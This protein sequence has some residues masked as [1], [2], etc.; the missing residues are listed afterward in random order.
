MNKPASVAADWEPYWRG[1]ADFAALQ[2]D[3]PLTQHWQRMFDQQLQGRAPRSLLDVASGNGA[4]SAVA[5]QVLPAL[6]CCGLDLSPAALQDYRQ[7]CSGAVGVL[8]DSLQ[9]PFADA[10]FDLV[11]SQFGF[12][13]A[14]VGA[15]HEMLRMVAPGGSLLAVMHLRD[16]AI[17][18]ECAR[19]LDVVE[20]VRQQTVLRLTR[21]AF[22]AGF[23]LNAGRGSVADF[24]RAEAQFAPAVRGL[25]QLMHSHGRDTADGLVKR[26]YGDISEMYRH[27]S[28]YAE[29]EV[30]VWMEGMETELR[31]YSGR[32]QAMLTAAVGDTDCQQWCGLLEAHGFT[33]DASEKI[34]LGAD[35]ESAAWLLAAHPGSS[36]PG[37]S[38]FE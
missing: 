6:A 35:T 27:M 5:L 16:G 22:A 37:W 23:A 14:G 19:N 4:V 13:Y 11:V 9:M 34:K 38:G 2:S 3:G 29:A 28:A 17:F 21:Q 31:A 10:G 33:I 1:S 12:E 8:G 18:R 7:R 20:A 15:L 32:M 25:E 26:L 36:Y 24:K 30:M